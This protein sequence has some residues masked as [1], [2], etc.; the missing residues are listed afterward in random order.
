MNE[1]DEIDE[2]WTRRVEIGRLPLP[3][4]GEQDVALMWHQVPENC[5]YGQREMGL[6]VMEDNTERVYAHAKAC[7]FTPE[8]IITIAVTAPN[9]GPG[10][11]VGVVEEA[12]RR[13]SI[14]REFANLQAWFYPAAGALMLWEV[15]LWRGREE[16]PTQDFLLACLWDGFE[17]EL[18]RVFPDALE[19]I[20]PHEPN[21]DSRS[22]AA[23]LAERG[24]APHVD[25]TYRKMIG[26][27]RPPGS[28]A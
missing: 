11:Q 26:L 15:D 16:D 20:T 25:N 14:R 19:I 28:P 10:E 7:Y 4:E 27:N 24:Y 5:G 12:Q 2:Y 1:F 6:G 13:G 8:I 3:I 22:W 17:R 21:Y 9:A 23:F 18:L